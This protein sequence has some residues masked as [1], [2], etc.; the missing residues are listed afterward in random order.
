[1]L[2]EILGEE[3]RSSK[4]FMVASGIMELISSLVVKHDTTPYGLHTMCY[5]L[6]AIS[7]ALSFVGAALDFI[8]WLC[9]GSDRA[10][11]PERLMLVG[12][13]LSALLDLI[14]GVMHLFDWYISPLLA[15]ARI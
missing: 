1:M 14:K 2:K 4:G 5:T 13:S 12:A 15:P 11:N 9:Y 7:L 10:E 6:C 3:R 8:L